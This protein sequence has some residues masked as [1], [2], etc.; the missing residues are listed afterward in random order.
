M[1]WLFI[2]WK[3]SSADSA[4]PTQY[5]IVSYFRSWFFNNFTISKQV[6]CYYKKTGLVYLWPK[7][8]GMSRFQ[9]NWESGA[10]FSCCFVWCCY[11][12]ACCD[13]T[14][15]NY[16]WHISPRIVGGDT[17]LPFRGAFKNYVSTYKIFEIKNGTSNLSQV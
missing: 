3:I 10:F 16:V 8:S 15:H 9:N 5:L 12:L 17:F 7:K 13:Q 14:G 4:T 1:D 2:H 11:L 6:E